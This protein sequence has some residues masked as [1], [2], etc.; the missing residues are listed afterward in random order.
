MASKRADSKSKF[1]T[2]EKGK[3]TAKSYKQVVNDDK[4]LRDSLTTANTKI[5]NKRRTTFYNSHRPSNDYYRYTPT[6]VYRDPFDNF[7]FRYVTLTW[8]FH[9]WDQI[10]KTRFDEER[11]RELE[12][13]MEEMESQGMERDPNYTM[14]E[15]DPDLQYSDEELA[16]LQEAKEVLEFEAGEG[17]DAGGFG[18]LTM[19]LVGLVVCGG[20]YVV[21][22]R[23]Y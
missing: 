12:V 21:A 14:P 20:V 9:H 15:L 22:V 19:F 7:F 23:R 3:Q 11:L 4:M 5:R 6:S 8:M 16:N 10:D 13:K 2:A 18:W 17:A 1:M